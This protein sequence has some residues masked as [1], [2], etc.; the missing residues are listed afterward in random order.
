MPTIVFVQADATRHE[1][2]AAN[3]ISV[4]R[5]AIDAGIDGMVADCGGGLACATC[6][7]LLE[8]TD[9]SRL[10]PPEPTEEDMLTLTALERLPT[11]R[12]SCQIILTDELDGIIV[13]IADPQT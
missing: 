7:V 10:P 13:T 2:A 4:M 12:L 9:Y 11:S 6:H 3:G 5:A 1:V 8:P